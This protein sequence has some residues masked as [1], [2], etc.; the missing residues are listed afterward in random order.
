MKA[1]VIL[2]VLLA[3]LDQGSSLQCEVC[4]M[5][6][7]CCSGPMKT[8]DPGEDTCGIMKGE[9]ILGGVRIPIYTK[10][11][12]ISDV[13]RYAHF[14]MDFG[15]G[16]RQRTSIACC[17]GEACRTTS[18]KLPP[19]NTTPNGL[20]CP[21]CF[22]NGSHECG[23]EIV[24]CTGSETYCFD[25]AGTLHRGKVTWKAAGKGCTSLS[26]CKVP[27]ELLHMSVDAN[28]LECKPASPA[29]IKASGWTLPHTLSPPIMA[30]L[31]LAKTMS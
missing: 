25:L 10:S 1:P 8:C 31:I 20:Q 28:R 7:Y 9:A 5:K 23:N 17:T 30:G 16:I 21:A 11:C 26:D 15:T 29:A 13:C 3:F 4:H 19:L 22:V 2:Y 12:F 24:Y 18:V 6:G 27:Q 14:S